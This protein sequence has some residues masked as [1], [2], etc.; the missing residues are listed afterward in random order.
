M[1]FLLK[2]TDYKDKGFVKLTND[3][4]FELVGI[5]GKEQEK[6]AV[7]NSID[8]TAR[9]AL[10]IHK[11]RAIACGAFRPLSKSKIEI[12][13]MFVKPK[14]R[15]HSLSIIILT[16]LEIW[17]KHERFRMSYLE[18]GFK[19]AAAIESYHRAGYSECAKFG[20]YKESTYSICMCKDIS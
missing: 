14:Y 20:P 1:T 2:R 17:A 4:D 13:R 7:Y 16:E 15:G 9:V 19:Q 8:S 18:T 12:K 5:Y 11:N 3:L 6:F 10:I